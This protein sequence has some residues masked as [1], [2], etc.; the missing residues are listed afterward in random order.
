M[1]TTLEATILAQAELAWQHAPTAD[2][3]ITAFLGEAT[4]DSD[5]AIAFV[6]WS[7][8]RCFSA[9]WDDFTA[10]HVWVSPHEQPD[11]RHRLVERLL[12]AARANDGAP[13]KPT[14]CHHAA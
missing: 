7:V 13:R 2:D 10:A 5:R 11:P 9:V 8:E 6:Q 4:A 3:A 12:L 14:W 1:T